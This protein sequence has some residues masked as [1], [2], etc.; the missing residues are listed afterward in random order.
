MHRSEIV[1]WWIL[2]RHNKRGCRIAGG[3][4]KAKKEKGVTNLKEYLQKIFFE[5]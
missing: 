1:A 2:R 5:Q 4:D 3:S